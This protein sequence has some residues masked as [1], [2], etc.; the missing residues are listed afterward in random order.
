MTE[1]YSNS[2]EQRQYR[3][4]I[5]AGNLITRLN[6]VYYSVEDM[7]RML[8][9]SLFTEFE[10]DVAA[11][12]AAQQQHETMA[13][14]ATVNEPAA[15]VSETAESIT[16]GETTMLADTTSDEAPAPY[17]PE[18]SPLAAWSSE[19]TPFFGSEEQ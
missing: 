16:G 5:A 9:P 8:D 12:Y 17:L 4:P 7:K 6:N 14:V 2:P 18:E 3:D 15:A 1:G 19:E 10:A 13:D 11:R